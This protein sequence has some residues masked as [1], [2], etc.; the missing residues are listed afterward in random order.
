M[1][2]ICKTFPVNLLLEGSTALVVGGGRVGLRKTQSLLEAGVNVR[3]VCPDALEDFANLPI[4]WLQKNFEPADLEGCSLVI[5]CTDDKHV[6]RQVLTVARER[7]ILCSCADGNWAESDFIVP[8]MFRT[9]DVMVSVSTHGRSCQSAKETKEILF[10]FMTQTAPGVLF[11]HGI[12]ESMPMPLPLEELS[13]R[14]AFLNGLYEWA[15]LTTCHRTTFFAWA[16][17][18]L[19]KS[20]LLTHLF[21]FHHSP[22]AYTYTDQ[23]AMDHLTLLLAGVESR[24]IGE[25]HIVGQVRDAFDL[26]RANGWARAA[27]PKAYA[28]ALKRSGVLREAIA[29]HLPKIEVEALALEGLTGR[30]VIAGTGRLG[31]AT[32]RHARALGLEVTVLYHRRP[33]QGDWDCR[34]L[35]EWKTALQGASALVSA[36]SVETPYFKAEDIFIPM[37]DLGAPRNIAGEKGVRDLDAL[38]GAYLERTGSVERIRAI[39]L[40]AL[41][42]ISSQERNS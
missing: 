6:N 28:E 24:M 13:H 19:I 30:V 3:L 12:N 16:T 2:P 15:F 39:A 17:P 35:T 38:R 4:Q 37:I 36:L 1:R 31:E 41:K 29:P 40:A 20:G 8:A 26:A 34:P 42:Q 7:R 14:L 27:L 33:L 25:F 22:R 10:R 23:A 5:A 21:G 9:D 11:V 32:A 18:A